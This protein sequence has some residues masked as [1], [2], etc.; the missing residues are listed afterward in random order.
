[1][2][3]MENDSGY[4]MSLNIPGVK[5]SDVNVQIKDGIVSICAEC[6]SGKVSKL[7]HC[8]TFDEYQ[9]DEANA[10]ASLVNGVLTNHC[11][12]EG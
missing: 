5:S 1:M 3:I 9:I 2:K 12:K 6:K 10:M 4:F 7:S 8:I 11:S